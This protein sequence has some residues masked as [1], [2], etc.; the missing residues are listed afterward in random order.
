MLTQ[1]GSLHQLTTCDHDGYGNRTEHW[2]KF[3]DKKHVYLAIAET[4]AS[5]SASERPA[6]P[7]LEFI[8]LANDTVR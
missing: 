6:V 5:E 1:R 7:D 8:V 4:N 2:I 3:V